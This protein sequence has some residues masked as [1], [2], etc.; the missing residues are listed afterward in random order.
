MLKVPLLVYPILRLFL[1]LYVLLLSVSQFVCQFFFLS[2]HPL[3]P[4]PPIILSIYPSIYSSV[5]L[6]VHSF[7]YSSADLSIHWSFGAVIHMSTW[8][9]LFLLSVHPPT[10]STVYSRDVLAFRL[11][12]LLNCLMV[13]KIFATAT[14]K[15]APILVY[16]VSVSQALKIYVTH[17][18]Y[19]IIFDV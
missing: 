12:F 5:C 6:S 11:D 14:R 1:H 7:A 8:K 9:R 4:Y 2:S 13:V 16:Q 19:I 10:R 3:S 15:I 18:H 17:I